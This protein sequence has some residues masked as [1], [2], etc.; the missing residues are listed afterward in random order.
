VSLFSVFNQI[1]Q[2][3]GP[4]G[5]PY[6]YY[7]ALRD[8]AMETG[9]WIGWSETLGGHWV[10]AGWQ[11]TYD[12]MQDHKS[13]SNLGVTFPKYGTPN[14]RPFMLSGY[15]EPEHSRY[16]RLIQGPFSPMKA[17]EA[18]VQLR[19]VVNELI[20]GFIDKGTVDA[21]EA[22]GDEVPARLTAIILGLPAEHGDMYRRW[23]HAISD[24]A[25]GNRNDYTL[26]QH[27]ELGEYFDALLEDRRQNLGDDLFSLVIQSEIDG[28]GLT[29]EEIKDFWVVLLLGG[30]ENTAKLFGSIFWRLGWDPELRRRL[31]AHPELIPSA[32]D[33]FFRYYCPS[34]GARL[35]V[36][37]VTV[38]GVE[39]EPGQ[40]V[41]LAHPI[42]S[43]DP[44]KFAMPD[45]FDPQRSP[46]P[47]LGL[48]LGIHRC[49][50]AHL[51]RIEV[52]IVLE[53]FLRRIPEF[54][55]DSSVTPSWTQGQVAGM[56]DVR[57]AFPPS[58]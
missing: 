20:D 37:P 9:K 39:F 30:I 43:R 11:E 12:I 22:L 4:D 33:E 14:D 28:E 8:E 21:L 5:T 15:D 16:R 51:V 19:A 25:R 44:R 23:T 58:D 47:H 31:V 1:D 27:A 26:K 52:K 46:N 40:N 42:N 24:H 10:I 17:A 34:G 41:V 35:V 48:G 36:A 2:P 32:I 18:D 6:E 49:I 29:Y 55:L 7:E 57:L 38:H 50:G 13:F 45:V 56:H 54:S 3:I 53:E